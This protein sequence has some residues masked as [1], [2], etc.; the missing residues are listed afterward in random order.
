MEVKDKILAKASEMFLTYGIKNVTMD[1]L[2]SELGISKRTLY[3]LFKDKEDLVFQCLRYMILEDNKDILKIIDDSENVVEAIFK[4]LKHQ[5]ERRKQFPK[6]FIEDI[7]KYYEVVNNSFYACREDLK[8]F[9]ASFTLID[10]GV[11]QGVFR[12][13]LRTELVDGFLHEIITL[14]H[15][16]S[17]MHLLKP[18]DKD[19]FRNIILPYFRGISTLK[20]LELLD[21]YFEERYESENF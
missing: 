15:T 10:K 11:K 20:G 12:K 7:K 3:E 1:S 16:S 13:G 21:T 18:S 8:K 4:I 2:V 17:R 14:L 6:V 9:S 5:E 19:V